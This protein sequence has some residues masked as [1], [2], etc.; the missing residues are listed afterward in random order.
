MNRQQLLLTK[1]AEECTEIA[2][3][4][5]KAQQFGLEE[6]EPGQLRT[7]RERI[8]LE[9]DNLMAAVQMLNVDCGLGYVPNEVRM[10]AKIQKVDKFYQ[11][12]IECGQVRA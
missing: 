6:M 11:Y 3:R 9:L 10:L 2:Q 5:L 1:L 8:H 12:A 4:A 7:N